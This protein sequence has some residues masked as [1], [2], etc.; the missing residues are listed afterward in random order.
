MSSWHKSHSSSE[1]TCRELSGPASSGSDEVA[2]SGRETSE[3]LRTDLEKLSASQAIQMYEQQILM[4]LSLIFKL[5]V[6][7]GVGG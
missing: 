2:V 6:E 7:G 3:Q 1:P 5:A 4:F